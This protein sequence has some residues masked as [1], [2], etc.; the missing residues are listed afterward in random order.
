MVLGALIA[1]PAWATRVTDVRVGRHPTFTRVVFELDGPAG[2]KLDRSG[3]AE[4][5]VTLNASG[6]AQQLALPKSLIDRIDVSSQGP[7]TVARIR[8]ARAG[9]GLK[10]LMLNSPS[11]IVFDVLDEGG[12]PTPAVAKAPAPAPKPAPAPVVAKV[13]PPAPAPTPAPEVEIDDEPAAAVVP[14]G[15]PSASASPAS[16][17]P[18]GMSGAPNAIAAAGEASEF[19]TAEVPEAPKPGAIPAA[20][21][22]APPEGAPEGAPVRIA[23]ATPKQPVPTDDSQAPQATAPRTSLPPA[24]TQA[25]EHSISDETSLLGTGAIALAGVALLVGGGA[26]IALRRRR[27]GELEDEFDDE[28]AE[29]AFGDDNPFAGVESAAPTEQ[30]GGASMVGPADDDESQTDLFAGVP[31]SAPQTASTSGA[32]ARGAETAQPPR[33]AAQRSE[34]SAMTMDSSFDFD[35][36]SNATTSVPSMGGVDTDAI[37]RLIR[38]LESRVNDLE[39]RLEEAV[40]AKERL[41]RQ[42]AA[43]TEELRVQR[44]AIARTQRAVRNL[45]Q[46]AEDTPTEP[47]LREPSP[48]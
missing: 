2:Y 9:L 22:V 48:E 42:V 32:P 40:D 46:P 38:N 15:V 27:A 37:M 28:D 25:A 26:L 16:P 1:A 43:Q 29:D 33:A 12:A 4:L 47:A 23:M 41:E 11:R 3:S 17:S 5:V 45:S 31:A 14:S 35:A 8:L 10:E 13:E 34:G 19:E 6:K 18:A 39:S 24:T 36:D 21:A 7:T 20:S 30:A 44:A